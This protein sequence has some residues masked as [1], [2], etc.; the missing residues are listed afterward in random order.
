VLLGLGT[1]ARADAININYS[2]SMVITD[3]GVSGSPAVG[4]LGISGTTVDTLATT[5]IG[6]VL[7]PAASGVGS[8]LS[9]G[10]F[11]FTPPAS[12]GATT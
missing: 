8:A 1:A 3:I 6:A 12:G 10:A 11:T 5:T 9:L 2:T 7:D 4:Y